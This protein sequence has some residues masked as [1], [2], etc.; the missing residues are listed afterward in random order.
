[1]KAKFPENFEW[2]TATA[3]YQ[4]EGGTWEDGK[5]ENIWDRFTHT[6]GHIADGTN[7]DVACDFY[8]RYEEDIKLAKEFGLQVYRFS[9]NW[10]RIFPEGTGQLNQKGIQFYKD[11]LNCLKEN[12]IKAAVTL[13]HWDLPQS[14]QDR[15]GWANKEI[16]E[17]FTN[18][19]KVLYREFGDLV[20]YWITLNEP[21]CTSFLGY[22]TGEHAPGYR[23]YS[24][25]LKAVHHLMLS[26]GA[27][28]KAYRETKCRGKIGITLNMNLCKP[29]N[30]K[31]EQDVKA[32]QLEQ[33]KG[34][35]LFCSPVMKGEYPQEL[36]DYLKTQGVVIPEVTEEDKKLLGPEI[37][38]LGINM[39]ETAYIRADKECWPLGG[40]GVHTGRSLTDANWQ[41]TPEGIYEILQYV[42]E[43]YNPKEIIITENGAAI[44]DWV[45]SDGR[46]H[47]A[48]REEYLRLY[49]EQVAK[50]IDEGVPVTGY[51]VWCFCDN[52]EW[53][54]GLARRFGLVYVDYA[55]QKRI[56]KD[57]LYWYK[58][59]IQ[60]HGF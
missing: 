31:N 3:S 58:E 59:V 43:K 45:S 54:W 42:N 56:P 48:N 18:Y 32:A 50:A 23:D 2:G 12:G 40:K 22:W 5:G 28:V 11:V 44:N 7:G 38:F 26:H 15:G 51:Y 19:V 4:I 36:F 49:L 57:S 39:Y 20:D 25:A 37:D 34:V 53:A 1:M 29:E 9:I 8:H 47:D 33:L 24:M 46:V 13:Y 55:T 60:N 6:P 10:A 27:A 21:L 30:P 16:V 35:E 14:L 41:V 52:F 17:W